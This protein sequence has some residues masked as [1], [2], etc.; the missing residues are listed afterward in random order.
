MKSFVF[1]LA[2]IVAFACISESKS[3]HTG[4]EEEENLEDSELTDLVAAALLEELAEA[5]EMDDL[6]Y[7]EEAG[8]ERMDKLEEMALK[9]KDKL[10]TMAEKGAQMGEKLKEMLPKA[11]EKLKELMEKMKNK[12]G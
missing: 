1:A 5:S 11:M 3:D 4:Y 12:M 9:L 10:K 7:T 2:L 8:G 6:S